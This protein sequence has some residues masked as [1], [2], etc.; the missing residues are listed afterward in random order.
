[1]LQLIQNLVNNFKQNN[2]K[3]SISISKSTEFSNE[4]T[5]NIFKTQNN[6][7]NAKTT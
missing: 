6:P 3:T 5:T 4:L 2:L 1:M 7:N